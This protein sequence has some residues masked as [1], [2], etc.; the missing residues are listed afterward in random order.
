[1]IWRE[2]PLFSETSI[3]VLSR[4]KQCWGRNPAHQAASWKVVK[5]QLRSSWLSI[6]ILERNLPN[7]RSHVTDPLTSTI[8]RAIHPSPPAPAPDPL[9]LQRSAWSDWQIRNC[10]RHKFWRKIRSRFLGGEMVLTKKVWGK[11]LT[12]GA[13]EILHQF[14]LFSIAGVG[15][16]QH[17]L[18]TFYC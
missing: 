5:V 18:Y 4:D 13:G 16:A 1:M 9:G 7:F 3:S 6:G 14:S 8:H 2:N 11:G 17:I 15:E 10:G 12:L